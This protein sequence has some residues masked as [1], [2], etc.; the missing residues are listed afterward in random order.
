MINENKKDGED[1]DYFSTEH[2][3]PQLRK[4][5][6]RGTGATVI[7]NTFNF[8]I[9]V[10]GTIILSRILSPD[11]FGLVAMVIVISLL[12]GNFG[13][14]GFTEAII[15]VQKVDHSQ[16]ST[17]FWV[18]TI[19]SGALTL[20]FM[21]SGPILAWLY[22]DPRIIDVTVVS[23]CLIIITS[24]STQ[25]LALLKRRMQFYQVAANT[26]VAVIISTAMS[27]WMALMGHGY[28]S[29]IAKHV[30][31]PLSITIGAWILCK[32][33]PGFLFDYVRVK[34]M[35]KF[36]LNVYGN[37]CLSYL[38]RNV[39]KI[40]I[41]KFYGS[42]QLGQYDRAYQLFGIFHNQLTLP[43]SNV[44]VATLS[45]LRNDPDKCL[46]YYVKILS[47][48]AFIGM[49]LSAILTLIGNDFIMLLIGNQWTMA[50]QV[51]TAFGP[52]VGVM[53]IYST[54]IWLHYSMGRADRLLRWS[55]FGTIITIIFFLIGLPFGGVGVALGYTLSYFVL[56]IPG[57]LYSGNPI[58]LKL[59][60]IFTAVWRYFSA[61]LFSYSICFYVIENTFISLVLQEMNVII[62]IL[63][64][65]I[66]CLMIYL[67]ILICLYKGFSPIF[68]FLMFIHEMIPEKFIRK[69]VIKFNS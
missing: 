52:G 53:L 60:H 22:T 10:I 59:S 48:I 19:I 15:Q 33:R 2:L 65:S 24:M 34:N 37:F 55:I 21:A 58:R 40:L 11:D 23:A 43:V 56:V 44:A 68:Q 3:L 6:L 26:I 4:M 13:G 46:Q 49:P 54:H 5:A 67:I 14:N 62:K 18:N 47:M 50:G 31:Y 63:L 61:G 9:Q 36:A 66:C 12:L 42:V 32:W 38:S 28:W 57:I 16:T 7:A 30:S 1:V 51:F 29:L 27:I 41:G 64:T 17:L 35:I 39:D 25:H 45:R 8:G 69:E 20:I